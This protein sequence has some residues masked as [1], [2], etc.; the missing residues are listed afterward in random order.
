M[1]TCFSES[2][3]VCA[4]VCAG[5]LCQYLNTK[6]MLPPHTCSAIMDVKVGFVIV[7]LCTLAIT[8]TEAGIPK[9]CMSTKSDIRAR[10]LMNVQRWEMQESNGAC[11]IQAL[12]LY[13]KNFKKPVCAHPNLRRKL[14][15]ILKIKDQM[16]HQRPS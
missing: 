12:V 9:C 2:S 10:I 8:S 3:W 13:V 16:A 6:D 11:D 14:K 4:Q 1:F 5:L 7:F 15:I